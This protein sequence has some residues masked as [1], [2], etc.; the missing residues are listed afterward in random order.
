MEKTWIILLALSIFIV[1]TFLFR[2]M[3]VG[4][5]KKEYGEKSRKLWGQKTFYWQDVIY[6]STGIT[7]VILVVL[8]WVDVI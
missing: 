7:F 8:K 3:T 5:F 1:V 2:K 6:F 4:H